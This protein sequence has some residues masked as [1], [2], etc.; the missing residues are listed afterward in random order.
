MGNNLEDELSNDGTSVVARD[1]VEYDGRELN[2]SPLPL[3][4]NSSLCPTDVAPCHFDSLLRSGA[5]IRDTCAKEGIENPNALYIKSCRNV[6]G[7]CSSA[8]IT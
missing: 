4:I 1:N 7:K 8:L 2:S 5:K 3:V 6:F